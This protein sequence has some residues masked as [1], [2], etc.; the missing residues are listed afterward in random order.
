ML[1]PSFILFFSRTFLSS[2]CVSFKT[3]KTFNVTDCVQVGHAQIIGHFWWQ[4]SVWIATPNHST[5]I[6]KKQLHL[7]ATRLIAC[8]LQD[9][10]VTR[11]KNGEHRHLKV[12]TARG[13]KFGV[14]TVEAVHRGFGKHGVVLNFGLTNSWAIV[15]DED[16]FWFSWTKGAKSFTVTKFVFSWFHNK[17]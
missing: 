6:R 1:T 12:T 5:R 17:L 2:N 3:N 8:D 4:K 11:F 13:T 9:V 16:K 14:S 10:R 7:P 15:G